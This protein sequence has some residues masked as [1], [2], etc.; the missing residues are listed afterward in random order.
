MAR[1]EVEY[2][3]LKGILTDGY[4]PPS[5]SYYKNIDWKAVNKEKF[6]LSIE[7]Q[8]DFKENIYRRFMTPGVKPPKA[9]P[10]SNLYRKMESMLEDRFCQYNKEPCAQFQFPVI[11][12]HRMGLIIAETEKR[13]RDKV[14]PAFSREIE[15]DLAAGKDTYVFHIA[16]LDLNPDNYCPAF[17]G[18]SNNWMD[19]M[20]FQ[21]KK[22]EDYVD[23]EAYKN[24]AEI[25]L[26]E[27][28]ELNYSWFDK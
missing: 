22:K 26:K 24:A 17:E 3:G 18:C 14:I 23:F 1:I 2:I 12:V 7:A 25:L 9:G 27:D 5:F 21:I 15:H 28:I 19:F 13:N 8:R 16:F 20:G 6:P 10:R 11:G 4:F